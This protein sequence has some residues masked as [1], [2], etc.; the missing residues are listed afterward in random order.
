[1]LSYLLRRVLY[2]VPIA[3]GVT[4]LAFLLVHIAPGDPLNA[5]APADAPKEVIDALKSAYGLDRPLPVQ[6]ALWLWRALH[7]DLGSSIATGRH[8]LDEVLAAVGNTL[9]LA[10]AA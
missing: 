10:G 7:G 9:R 4:L 5:I 8:V 3:L 1:M 6:Y 2:A